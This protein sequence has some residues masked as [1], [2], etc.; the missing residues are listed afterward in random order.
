MRSRIFHALAAC[1]IFL[2]FAMG[3]SLAADIEMDVPRVGLWS[4]AGIVSYIV[5]SHVFGFDPY[6][7]RVAAAAA[8]WVLY[9]DRWELR[10]G[11]ATLSMLACMIVAAR[12]FD[13]SHFVLAVVSG[14]LA[15]WTYFTCRLYGGGYDTKPRSG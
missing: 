7:T 6:R 3:F 1:A 5:F 14:T 11:Q 13:D 12:L 9:V 10:L 2:L 15:A 8:A 4:M